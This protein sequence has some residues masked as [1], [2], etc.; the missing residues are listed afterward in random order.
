MI[1]MGNR[2]KITLLIGIVLFAFILERIFITASLFEK[3]ELM[4]YDFR[5]RISTDKGLF[6]DKFKHAD[7]NIA[8]V[9][10]DDNS[11][12]EIANYP[13]LNLG[14]WPW[15]RSVWADVINYIEKGQPKA[16]IF[17]LTFN[18]Y[19]EDI[20]N[21]IKL[22]NTL[23]KYDN[24]VL[25]TVLNSP[26]INSVSGK[27]LS[28]EKVKLIV[29]SNY[30][31]VPKS[32]DVEIKD[33]KLDNLITYY[34][35]WPI[36]DIYTKHNTMGVVNKVRDFDAVIRKSQPVFKLEKDGKTYYMPSLSFAGFLKYMG[37]D[38]KI[39]IKD[40][41]LNYKGRKIPLNKN[42]EVNI[43]W[44]GPGHDYAFIPV[45]KIL[46]NSYKLKNDKNIQPEYFK[47]KIIV[48]GRS[49]TGSDI[50]ASAVNAFYAGAESNAVAIDNL[51]NDGRS[52]I[53]SRKFITEPSITIDYI[54]TIFACLAIIGMGLASKNAF[55]AFLNSFT[56]IIIYVLV[57]VF[58]FSNPQL[59]IWIPIVS[60][61]YYMLVTSG[62][63]FAIRLQ[64]EMAKRETI[65]N[66][67]GKF[68]SPKVLSNIMKHQD[69]LTLRHSKKKIT[70]MFCDV[71]GFTSLSEKSDPEELMTALNELFNVIVD[72]IFKNN[73]TVDK[74]IGDCVMAYWGDP[75]SSEEDAYMAVKT[76][77]E[78]KKKVLE[79]KEKNEKNNKLSLD[80]KIGINT[81][82]AL[83]GLAGSEQIMS[84][85]AI[86]DAV[87]VASRLESSCSKLEKDILISKTTYEQ[88]KD[89][90]Q[91]E[92]V[93]KIFLKGKKEELEV[94][95]PI[96][97]IN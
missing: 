39:V 24:I 12:R 78:I 21:D 60:P 67:F 28:K 90:I 37:E 73:G 46:L 94:F 62:I 87:N 79:L 33:K 77:L 14:S 86:G 6:G 75:I 5:A 20:Q 27:E 88:T 9:V 52:K 4:T 49:E 56:F 15:R 85:T 40:G 41:V 64:K 58:L 34:S 8:L 97:L 42:G 91:F 44:H 51:I 47:D 80:V 76:A 30:A 3:L 16:I 55:L 82:E 48:I 10:V 72:I 13:Q 92:T 1:F 96:S 32:L 50:H 61:L 22:S 35:H 23:K 31:P 2:R 19:N 38:G 54:I 70:M 59:R 69:N 83:L 71:K 68:V 84:Y 57:S 43:G 74:F 36:P 26:K 89:K 17:D 66:I 29:N 81:G 25:A 95:E 18:N 7:K 45:S 63:V 53:G 93:G 11:R 65:T